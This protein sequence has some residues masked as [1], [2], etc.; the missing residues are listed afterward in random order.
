M[1]YTANAMDG[2]GT[3]KQRMRKNEEMLIDG[4]KLNFPG[5]RGKWDFSKMHSS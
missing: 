3:D 4:V 2:R 1:V 5:P